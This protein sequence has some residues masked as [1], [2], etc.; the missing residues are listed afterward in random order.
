MKAW[1]MG[2]ALY[3]LIGLN[4]VILTEVTL[5]CQRR[6]SS[7]VRV[8]VFAALAWPVLL[9]SVVVLDWPRCPQGKALG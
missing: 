4:L 9:A 6:Q 5:Q 2:A 1:L 7:V 8:A 3:F